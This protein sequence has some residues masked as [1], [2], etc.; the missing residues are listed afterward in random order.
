MI[1]QETKKA[2]NSSSQMQETAERG[3]KDH[4]ESRGGLLG[5]KRSFRSK[6]MRII[7]EETL[8]NV[9]VEFIIKQET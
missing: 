3:E 2:N 7:D 1:N 5:K 4:A 6:N 9:D 8:K